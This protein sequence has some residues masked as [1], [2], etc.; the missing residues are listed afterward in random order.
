MLVTETLSGLILDH[1]AKSEILTEDTY[2]IRWCSKISS[3]QYIKL[4]FMLQAV[5]I[6]VSK[7][8]MNM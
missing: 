7:M 5:D 4:H 1:I 6:S 2:N 3:I 8:I